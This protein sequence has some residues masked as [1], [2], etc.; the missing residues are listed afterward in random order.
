MCGSG[1]PAV[2]TSRPGVQLTAS[3]LNN[4][5]D[6]FC[7]AHQRPSARG[8][9]MHRTTKQVTCTHAVCNSPNAHDIQSM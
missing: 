9:R 4:N 2:N 7:R 5:Y 1:R 6:W 3:E 8:P